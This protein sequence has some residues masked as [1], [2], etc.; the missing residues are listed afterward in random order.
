MTAV[1]DPDQDSETVDVSNAAT[2]GGYAHAATVVVTVT[3]DDLQSEEIGVG[4]ERA[5]PPSGRSRT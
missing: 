3:D 1:D 5:L 2:G 4:A